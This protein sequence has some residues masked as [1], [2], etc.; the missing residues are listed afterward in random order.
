MITAEELMKLQ[1]ATVNYEERTNDILNE[2]ENHLVS[3]IHEDDSP[4]M[5]TQLIHELQQGQYHELVINN[6][7]NT[8]NPLGY[9]VKFISPSPYHQWGAFKIEWGEAVNKEEA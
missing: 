7:I 2:I 9:S 1:K 6:V 8:M 5:R 3:V 4:M